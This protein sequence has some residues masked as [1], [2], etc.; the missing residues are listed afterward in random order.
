MGDSP[1]PERMARAFDSEQRQQ[2]P[3]K[4]L[5]L[6]FQG[7]LRFHWGKSHSPCREIQSSF[8]ESILRSLRA[9]FSGR[10]IHDQMIDA[11]PEILHLSRLPERTDN[12]LPGGSPPKQETELADKP[13]H[14][15][16]AVQ[17]TTTAMPVSVHMLGRF[18]MSIQNV[19]LKL[20]ALR[21]LSLLKYL[22]LNHRQNIPREVLMD[23]F[24]PDA[25]PETARNNLNVAIHAFHAPTLQ[26]LIFQSSLYRDGAYSLA[27]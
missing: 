2:G 10:K 21:S 17:Q 11:D 8:W 12:F 19:A 25:E 26:L 6:I 1:S 15:D 16:H 20:P 4:T 3:W 22:M 5:K 18:V 27:P 24:W 13:I 23:V 9:Y 7:E 14:I